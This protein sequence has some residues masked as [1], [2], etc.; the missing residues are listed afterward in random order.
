MIIDSDMF[1]INHFDV[2]KHLNDFTIIGLPQKRKHITYL[3]NGIIFLN[4]NKLILYNDKISFEIIRDQKIKTDVGGKFFYFL[5]QYPECLTKKI[6]VK[7]PYKIN[8]M[9]ID[10]NN[11][12]Y[13]FELFFNKSFF[14]YRAATNWFSL[15]WKNNKEPLEKKLKIFEIIYEKSIN[16]NISDDFICHDNNENIKIKKTPIKKLM[17]NIYRKISIPFNL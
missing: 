14:H 9:N 10:I 7:Y 3:W 15:S 17:I 12:N 5:N 6:D 13:N 8:G 2:N 1:L 16:K 11:K 4:M